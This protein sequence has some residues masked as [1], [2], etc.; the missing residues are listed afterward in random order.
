MDKGKPGETME[1]YTSAATRTAT[2]LRGRH[3]RCKLIAL[4]KS[5][6]SNMMKEGSPRLRKKKFSKLI[7]IYEVNFYYL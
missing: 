2:G 7:R 1:A 5:F 6:R 3:L 4:S